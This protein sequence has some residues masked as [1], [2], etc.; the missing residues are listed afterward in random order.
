[1][2]S[3]RRQQS[4]GAMETVKSPEYTRVTATTRDG[5]DD[6]SSQST[7]LAYH[8]AENPMIH[9]AGNGAADGENQSAWKRLGTWW[10]DGWSA[11]LLSC[12]IATVSLAA[13]IAVLSLYDGRVLQDLPI[14][15][16][17]ARKTLANPP[18]AQRHRLPLDCGILHRGPGSLALGVHPRVGRRRRA[19]HRPW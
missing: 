18:L 19:R 5:D 4:A 16:S 14:G 7:R 13:L 10:T 8:G 17:R 1:M 11:E 2:F 15:I 9:G 12:V 3:F 6:T